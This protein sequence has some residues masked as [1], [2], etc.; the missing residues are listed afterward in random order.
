LAHVRF[1]AASGRI[2]NE[3]GYEDLVAKV[4]GLIEEPGIGFDLPLDIRGT[5]FQRRV[6]KALQQIPP[7]STVS[8]S[9]IANKIGMPQAV[10]AVAQACSENKLAVAI[11]CH[12]VVKNDGS[13]S[14][15]RWGVERK[16]A[17]LERETLARPAGRGKR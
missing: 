13:L 3:P 17:L 1:K 7:G 5:A 15:Y 12:R 14:G 10:R 16:R 9:D 4:V 2:Q 11:P 6:W 8:Y